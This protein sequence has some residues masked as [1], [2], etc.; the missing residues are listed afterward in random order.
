MFPVEWSDCRKFDMKTETNLEVRSRLGSKMH[1]K[2]RSDT[3]FGYRRHGA[4]SKVE[5]CAS[6]C[7]HN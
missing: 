7:K 6:R 5:M 4:L 2:V 1:A 3:R